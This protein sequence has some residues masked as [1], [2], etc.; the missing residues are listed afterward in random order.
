MGAL[1]GLADRNET[2][3]RAVPPEPPKKKEKDLF[4]GI[5]PSN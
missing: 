3:M 4:E 1:M 5:S 2:F